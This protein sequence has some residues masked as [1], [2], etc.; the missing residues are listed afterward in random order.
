MMDRNQITKSAIL[1]IIVNLN[2]T[3][4]LTFDII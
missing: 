2:L 4:N 3:R 1:Q